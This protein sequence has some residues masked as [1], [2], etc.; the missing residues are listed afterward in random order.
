MG[1]V[2]E[3]GKNE[4][5]RCH[6]DLRVNLDQKGPQLEREGQTVIR[7]GNYHYSPFS[8]FQTQSTPIINLF[9]FI[10]ILKCGY[11]FTIHFLCA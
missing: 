3:T 7:Y 11:N 2:E 6:E 1:R 5:I 4:Q 10:G 8:H 9:P